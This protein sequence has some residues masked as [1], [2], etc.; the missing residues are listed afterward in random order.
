LRSINF[1]DKN[2]LFESDS[3]EQNII[4]E[5]P[6]QLKLSP[7][8]LMDSNGPNANPN[9]NNQTDV[10]PYPYVINADQG[11][12]VDLHQSLHIVHMRGVSLNFVKLS[13]F[14]HLNF[15]CLPKIT[16]PQFPPPNPEI[17]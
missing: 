9:S 2:K 11:S 14:D 6:I 12:D 17:I 3:K 16:Y 8:R 5:I 1:P 13:G 10:L 4:F 7:A 15:F